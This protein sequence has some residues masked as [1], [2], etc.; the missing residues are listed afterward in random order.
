[1]EREDDKV[2]IV[3][4]LGKKAPATTLPTLIAS[5]VASMGGD[6]RRLHFMTWGSHKA[7]NE[8]CDVRHL[9]VVGVHQAPLSAIIGLV[10]GT[11][12]VPMTAKVSHV[13]VQLMR[14][15]EIRSDLLQAV[16]RGASRNMINGDGPRGCSLHLIARSQGPVA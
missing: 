11:L 16:G 2:L 15:S 9:I 5:K 8:Y 13:D 1:M 12:E 3:H 10:H 6:P 4:R 14:M 7:T